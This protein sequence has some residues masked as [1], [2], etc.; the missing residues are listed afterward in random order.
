MRIYIFRKVVPTRTGLTQSLVVRLDPPDFCCAALRSEWGHSVVARMDEP[1]KPFYIALARSVKEVRVVKNDL[2]SYVMVKQE[3]T[4]LTP[5]ISFCPFCGE[6]F[7]IEYVDQP[8][9]VVVS[10]N[11]N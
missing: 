5:P 10:G 6:R 8:S 3:A 11:G 7:V 9:I 1:D 4:T 2:A